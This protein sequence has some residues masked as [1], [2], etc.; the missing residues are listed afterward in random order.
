MKKLSLF[1]PIMIILAIACAPQGLAT[2]ASAPASLPT[3][4][5]S[6]TVEPQPSQTPEAALPPFQITEI[7]VESCSQLVD[8]TLS[9]TGVPEITYTYNHEH[10]PP[11]VPDGFSGFVHLN[12]TQ[13]WV[14]REDDPQR[15]TPY[16]LPSDALGPQVS[17]DRQWIIFRRDAEAGTKS[18]FWVMDVN[19]Q[20]ERKLATVSFEEVQARNP[21]VRHAYLEYGWIPHMNSMYYGIRLVGAGISLNPPTY[22]AFV[23]ME[24]HSGKTIPLVHS[25]TS[26]NIRFAA[27]GSQIAVVTTREPP[28]VD[29]A[30]YGS[31]PAALQNGGDLRLVNTS[32]GSVRFTLPIQIRNDF[33]EFSPDGNHVLGYSADGLVSMNVKDG[34]WQEIPLNYTAVTI[35][36]NETILPP[37][38]WEDNATV[39]ASITNL[40]EGVRA[41]GYTDVLIDPNANF[42]IWR[43]NLTDASAQPVQT[44]LGVSTSVEFSPDGKYL[45]FRK[46]SRQGNSLGVGKFAAL[47]QSTVKLGAA[48]ESPDLSLADLGTGKILAT[49]E[50]NDSFSW[51][52]HPGLYVYDQAGDPVDD[53]Y[54]WGI[55]LGQVGKEPLFITL[56]TGNAPWL[57]SLLRDTQWADP[58]RFVMNIGCKIGLV[59]LTRQ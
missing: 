22:D 56:E 55:F 50:A 39:L 36:G 51:S 41:T 16:P 48:S 10:F 20:N 23:L 45:T 21:E 46:N 47:H 7:P 42:T 30:N 33:L 2:P 5:V 15:A 35:N 52:P 44:F 27:D 49:L 13:L 54:P 6:A 26:G 38:A 14:W 58:E 18:E 40:P 8:A 43:V 31:Q 24:I 29:A 19:G 32:D 53:I 59:E 11:Y 28:Q 9:S 3:S 57:P 17:A 34:K 12:Y 25:G 1:L 4:P 37:S